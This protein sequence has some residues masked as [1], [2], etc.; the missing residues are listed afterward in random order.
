MPG[1]TRS[2]L[3]D[4]A[5]DAAIAA[6]RTFY[7]SPDATTEQHS[8]NER[9]AI[10]AV[11]HAVGEYLCSHIDLARQVGVTGAS[12]LAMIEDRDQWLHAYRVEQQQ[13]KLYTERVREVGRSYAAARLSTGADKQDVAKELG[14]S[15]PTLDKWLAVNAAKELFDHQ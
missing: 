15:R 9:A 4:E 11:N 10:K 5:R 2:Q 7:G 3:R 12:I 13:L 8:R 1:K 6:L 14:I